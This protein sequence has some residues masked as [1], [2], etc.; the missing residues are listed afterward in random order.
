[1][2][3]SLAENLA[4]AVKTNMWLA[5]LAALIGGLLTAANPCV[6]AM[7][8]LMIGYMARQSPARSLGRSVGLSVSF[9]AGLTAVF[10]LLF[11]GTLVVSS[12]LRAE[13]WRYVAAAVCLL[14]G[15][16]LV[17]LIR[18]SLP[19]PNNP[20][21][22]RRGML[23]A[24]GLGMVFGTVSLPCAGPILL[25]LLAVMPLYGIAYGTLLLAAYSLGHCTLVL[26]A[27]ISTGLVQRMVDSRGLQR[28]GNWLKG[29]AG[30]LIMLVGLYLLLG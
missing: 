25:A 9:V 21:A 6:L 2:L 17:G 26:A 3:E 22:A 8:P 24:L 30:G 27:G 29:L 10:A 20:S 1:M 12:F 19:G 18:F 16:D 14:M 7:V 28:T 13:W 11:L 23:G 15:L 5:P 4:A